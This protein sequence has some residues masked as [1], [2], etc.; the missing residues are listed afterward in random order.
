[1]KKETIYLLLMMWFILMSCMSSLILNTSAATPEP[2]VYR[3]VYIK[4]IV[5][6]I[7]DLGDLVE[8]HE[9]DDLL[10]DSEG[11]VIYLNRTS[12]TTDT[13]YIYNAH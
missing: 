9:S 13:V 2:Q 1:M 7:I 12:V 6:R 8:Y 5:C 11:L 3:G 10:F 4:E